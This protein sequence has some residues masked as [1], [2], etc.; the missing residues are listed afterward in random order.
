M[1]KIVV[2][3]GQPKDPD[4]FRTYYQQ[5]HLPLAAQLPGLR[6]SRH[7]FD[8]AAPEGPAPFFCMWEGEFDSGEA[9]AAAMGS[10]IGRRVAADTANYATGG[11]TLFHC[12]PV[13]GNKG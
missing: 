10:E 2:L 5:K 12:G 11:L 4:H 8:I 1:R 3:Y 7:S 6:A 13:E 9:L